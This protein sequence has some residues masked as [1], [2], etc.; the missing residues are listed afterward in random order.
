[1]VVQPNIQTAMYIK[2]K[3]S[4]L[5]F[6]I[7]LCTTHYS[8]CRQSNNK[9]YPNIKVKLFN[10]YYKKHKSNLPPYWSYHGNK[11]Y[12]NTL[13][14]PAWSWFNSLSELLHR[15]KPTFEE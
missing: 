2:K 13:S 8:K 12:V 4:A 5:Y 10:F 15:N 14:L 1:M 3:N 6:E 11:N 9:C 7:T